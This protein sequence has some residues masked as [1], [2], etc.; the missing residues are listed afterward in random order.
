MLLIWNS[1]DQAQIGRPH[2]GGRPISGRVG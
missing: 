2:T 1:R